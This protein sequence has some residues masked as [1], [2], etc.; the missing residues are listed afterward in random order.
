MLIGRTCPSVRGWGAATGRAQ[1]LTASQ[2]WPIRRAGVFVAAEQGFGLTRPFRL[3]GQLPGTGTKTKPL[4][5]TVTD[6]VI[7]IHALC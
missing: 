1:A 5:L 4:P 3:Y 6:M 2:P 7:S